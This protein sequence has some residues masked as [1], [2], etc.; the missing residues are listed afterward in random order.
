MNVVLLGPPG[1]GKGTQAQML[2]KQFRI[3]H[4]STGDMFRAA[5]K[6]GTE[7]GLQAKAV[8]DRG[9]LVPD[10]LTI[11]IVRERLA[12][13]DCEKGFLLDG[14][15]R[16]IPQA[17]AL[18]E[19]LNGSKRSLDAAIN[20]EVPDDVLIPRMTGRRVCRQCGATYHIEFNPPQVAS[21]C[22]SCCGELYQRS[23]D[24]EN[25]VASRLEVYARQTQPLVDYYCHRKLLK[26]INGNQ[27]LMIVF[28]QICSRLLEGY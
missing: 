19:I 27:N 20:I 7:L 21:Q 18:N 8:M 10:E 5:I 1:S 23:D 25:T 15:P 12:E 3:P 4:I 13:A 11:G 2:V 16:T 17:D 26:T 22:D 9:Q 14:F 6:Q 24:T 28:N